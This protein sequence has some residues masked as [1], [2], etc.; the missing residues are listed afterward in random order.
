M[1][2]FRVYLVDRVFEDGRRF[3][4]KHRHKFLKVLSNESLPL[5][6]AWHFML[7]I[8]D[9]LFLGFILEARIGGK[10]SSSQGSRT[11][12]MLFWSLGFAV[13]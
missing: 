8:M 1:I 10:K 9:L 4:S 2:S 11:L 6:Y 7:V 5:D 12:C 3:V 13:N